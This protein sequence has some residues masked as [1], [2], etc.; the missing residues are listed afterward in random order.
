MYW[1]HVF[2]SDSN[3]PQENAIWHNL[4]TSN[5]T[6]KRNKNKLAKNKGYAFIPR[7]KTTFK[8]ISRDIKG[9]DS[10][11]LGICNYNDK[12]YSYRID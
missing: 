2:P 10:N 8:V 6:L 11:F 4:I 3:S 7:K 9:K 5:K 1:Q 12:I